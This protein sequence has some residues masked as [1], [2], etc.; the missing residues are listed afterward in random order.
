LGERGARPRLARSF[1]R[2]GARGR[3]ADKSEGMERGP[4]AF[5]FGS[6]AANKVSGSAVRPGA[7]ELRRSPRRSV[8]CARDAHPARAGRARERVPTAPRLRQLLLHGTSR[9][10]PTARASHRSSPYVRAQSPH[11]RATFRIPRPASPAPRSAAAD[12]DGA[13]ACSG[14]VRC[15]GSTAVAWRRCLGFWAHPG[16]ADGMDGRRARRRGAVDPEERSAMGSDR[17]PRVARG[18]GHARPLLWIPRK[19]SVRQLGCPRVSPWALWLCVPTLPRVCP[20]RSILEAHNY[21]T[22]SHC[23]QLDRA[24]NCVAERESAPKGMSCKDL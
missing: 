3:C 2:A 14:G 5:A 7:A 8:P 16:R 21:T 11:P 19:S 20:C 1:G 12:S 24:K 15:G 22:K 6:R 9:A 13:S 17:A 23:G 4:H 18:A 10:V